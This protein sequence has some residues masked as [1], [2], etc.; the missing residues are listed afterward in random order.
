M[1]WAPLHTLKDGFDDPNTKVRGMVLTDSSGNRHIG[2]AAKF[3]E[4]PAHPDFALP[5]YAPSAVLHWRPR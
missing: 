5:D 1:C 2:P 3:R 4:Q